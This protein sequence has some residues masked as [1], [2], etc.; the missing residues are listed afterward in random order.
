M[1]VNNAFLKFL[2]KIFGSVIFS[3]LHLQQSK[4]EKQ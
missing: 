3:D 4:K 2:E 1:P